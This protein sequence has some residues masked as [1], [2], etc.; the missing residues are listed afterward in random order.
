MPAW[1]HHRLILDD[2][3]RRLAKRD[4]AKSL[5]TLREQGWTPEQV[6]REVGGV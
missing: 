6:R 5:R 4:D 1:E 2:Q 3:G